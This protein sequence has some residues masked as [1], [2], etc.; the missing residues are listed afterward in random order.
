M[1]YPGSNPPE[2]GYPPPRPG[3]GYAS[4]SSGYPPPSRVRAPGYPSAPGPGYASLGVPQ[5]GY[6]GRGGSYAT[7]RG[8]GYGGGRERDYANDRG[9]GYASDRGGS[10][11]GSQGYSYG[12][13][14]T[15]YD[16]GR[17]GT[18][19]PYPNFD[20]RQDA[21]ALRKAMKGW[22][23][24]EDTIIN[25]LCSRSSTQR[26]EIVSTFKQMLGRDLIKDIKSE[27]SGNFK[28]VM[29]GLLYPMHEYLARELRSAMK[30]LGTD[31]DCLVE[32]LCTRSN[33]DIRRI[34]DA[35]HEVFGRDLEADIRSETSGHFRKLLV[36]MCNANREEGIAPDP[37]RARNDAHLLQQ[38]G[39]QR[40]GT[41]ESV[42]NQ[43]LASQSYEQLLLVFREYNALTNQTIVESI[44][45]EMSGDLRRGFLAIAKC[46]NNIPFYF[47]E[48]LYKSMKGLG[49]SDKALIRIVVSRCE[50]DMVQ[51]KEE[52]VRNY[53]TSLDSFIKSDTSG[54]Y[55][56]ALLALVVG[57]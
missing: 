32:I 43:I 54:D 55:R 53:K 3:G 45:R 24:D 14:S 21:Q 2:D 57:N 7:D 19:R 29:V 36:S 34:K 51:I 39:I 38:A 22:G 40:W 42:F 15:S 6:S 28:S 52:F 5:G 50:V 23:T 33:D 4:G 37:G 56:K 46:V 35:F 18:L 26:L 10:Y 27:L 20:A 17:Q 12:G 1:S 30:G 11:G 8:P 49:T 31:E 44:S 47:A 48:K 9:G 25:I 13:A 16:A 41:D